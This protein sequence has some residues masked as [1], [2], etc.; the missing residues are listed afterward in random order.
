MDAVDPSLAHDAS[1]MAGP[2]ATV[3]ELDAERNESIRDGEAIVT[4]AAGALGRDDVVTRVLEGRP[5][6]A[7]CELASEISATAIVMGT[8]GRGGFKRAMLGS[9]SDHVVRNAPCPVGVIGDDGN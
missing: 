6:P 8:R 3:E 2:T 7:L 1:G 4:A 5:G 9:V